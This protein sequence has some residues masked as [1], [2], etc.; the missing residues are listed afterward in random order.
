M[1]NLNGIFINFV[2]SRL[3]AFTEEKLQLQNEVQQLQQQLSEVKKGGRR[4]NSINGVL[5]GDDEYED[6]QRKFIQY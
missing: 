6:A 2:D 3:K 1:N 4:S 5:E